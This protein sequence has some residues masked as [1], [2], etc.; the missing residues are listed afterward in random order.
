MVPH[1]NE[2]SHP[3]F[4]SNYRVRPLEIYFWD[5]EVYN[6]AASRRLACPWSDAL[7]LSFDPGSHDYRWVKTPCDLRC[8]P[9]CRM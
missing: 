3:P 2:H 8:A 1:V 4:T 9:S 6:W 5:K 7:F